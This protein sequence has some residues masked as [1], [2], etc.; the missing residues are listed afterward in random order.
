MQINELFDLYPG[1]SCEGHAE[2]E[3]GD[4]ALEIDLRKIHHRKGRLADIRIP[5][6]EFVDDGVVE[7]HTR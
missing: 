7:F 2:I 1:G 5:E 3:V 4:A 6:R